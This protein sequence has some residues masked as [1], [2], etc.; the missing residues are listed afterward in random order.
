MGDLGAARSGALSLAAVD[1]LGRAGGEGTV[2]VQGDSMGPTF[3]PGQ[4]LRVVF[5]P[6]RLRRGDILL[7]RQGEALLVHRLLG[8]AR[9]QAGCRRLRTRGDGAAGLDPPLDPAL[10]LG[11]VVALEDGGVWRS[12]RTRRAR[13]YALALAW[14]DL[15]WAAVG[16]GLS[17]VESG[18]GRFGLAVALA[19]AARAVDRFLLGWLHRAL[20]RRLHAALEP[21]PTVD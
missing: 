12:F 2:R 6:N 14:H 17:A 13:L 4:R 1:L 18:L 3:G 9:P 5:A 7:F 15:F 21:V 8:R 20:F 10:V 16:V 19:P 11:R